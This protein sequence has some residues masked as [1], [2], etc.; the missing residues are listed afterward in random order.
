[1]IAT[2]PGQQ[3]VMIRIRNVVTM[4]VHVA[5]IEQSTLLIHSF[6]GVVQ[7]LM[8]GCPL[9]DFTTS[10]GGVNCVVMV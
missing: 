2:V 7:F 10:D 5:N 6:K 8:T 1:M 9:V 4:Y 3:L